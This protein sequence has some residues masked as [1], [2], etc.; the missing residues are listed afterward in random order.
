MT[1]GEKMVWAA[2]FVRTRDDYLE[3]S[4]TDEHAT[5]QAVIAADGAVFAL[6]KLPSSG[7]AMMGIMRSA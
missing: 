1:D 7:S 6:R 4:H 5:S 2:Q 3:C